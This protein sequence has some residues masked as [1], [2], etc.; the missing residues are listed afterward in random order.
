MHFTKYFNNHMHCIIAFVLPLLKNIILA[1]SNGRTLQ[2]LIFIFLKFKLHMFFFFCFV[3]TLQI[4][5]CNNIEITMLIKSYRN[6]SKVMFTYLWSFL[7]SLENLIKIT[8]LIVFLALEKTFI[9]KVI[10]YFE[11]FCWVDW[12]LFSRLERAGGRPLEWF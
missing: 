1:F 10:S 2:T 11:A 9:L 12:I 5:I 7:F 6:Y 8:I 3:S 4:G